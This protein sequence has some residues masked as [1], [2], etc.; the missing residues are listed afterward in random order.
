M[1]TKNNLIWFLKS[2]DTETSMIK[3]DGSKEGVLLV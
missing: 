1:I 3:R 2:T